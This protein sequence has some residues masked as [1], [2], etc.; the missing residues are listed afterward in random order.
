MKFKG[1]FYLLFLLFSNLAL[2]QVQFTAEASKEKLGINERLRI[3]F[4]MNQDGDNFKPPS[5]ENFTVVGGPNQ[6]VSNSWINGKRSYSKTYS[7]FL[8]PKKRGTFSIGQ[9]EITIEGEIYKTLGLEIEVTAAVEDP[10]AEKINNLVDDNIHLVAEISNTNPFLNEAINIEYKL[11]VSQ[12]VS[13]SNFREIDN[14][15]YNGFWS[16]NTSNQPSG[17][18]IGEF[19]GETYRYVVLRKVVL[20]PQKTGKLSIEPLTLSVAVDVP[21]G[22]RDFFGGR[23]YT[24]VDKTVA[25][26]RKSINV[27]PLPEGSPDNFNGAVGRNF[28]FSLNANKQQ[29]KTS[30]SL[31]LEVKLIGRGNLK[32]FNLPNPEFSEDLEVYEPEHHENIRVTENGMNGNI[33]NQYT[34]VPIKKGDYTIGP[35]SF[36]YFDLDSRSYKTITSEAINISVEQGPKVPTTIASANNKQPVELTGADFRFIKLKSDLQPLDDHV[37]VG[38]AA[39]WSI[40]AMPFLA[41]PLLILFSRKREEKA[42]DIRGNKIR[43]ADK[44]ARKYL[45]EAEKNLGDQKNFYVSLERALHNYLKSKL[46]ISTSEMS[47]D[48]IIAMLEN[49]NVEKDD[50]SAFIGLIESCEIARYTPASHEMMQQDYKKAISVIS[51][52]DKQL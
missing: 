44:L 1:V 40:F 29:L 16:Q 12:D 4:K 14:P 41:V 47:K 10:E 23:L 30:E 42:N 36:S 34:I 45:S 15:T 28:D 37:F 52:M 5:F 24:T 3:D 39:F 27:K 46:H 7:Y 49:K 6:A 48:N 50:I 31:E 35:I 21:T 22:E 17:V 9:A 32:L 13:V 33:S 8:Q 2:A 38:S 51:I 11:Y 26:G 18:Q 19:K 20:F 43:K 25:A